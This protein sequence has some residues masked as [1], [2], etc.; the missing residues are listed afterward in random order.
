MYSTG[1][2]KNYIAVYSAKLVLF[3]EPQNSKDEDYTKK[4]IGSK[5]RIIQKAN[6][7]KLLK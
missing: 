1:Q 2:Q 6:I 5:G 3:S 4:I 7:M